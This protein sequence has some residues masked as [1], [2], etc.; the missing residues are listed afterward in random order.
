MPDTVTPP[1]LPG[2]PHEEPPFHP[3]ELAAQARAGVRERLA[4]AGRRVIRGIMP[5]QHRDFFA[6]LPFV[7]VGSLDRQGR[8]W[9][10]ILSG[11]PGFLQ[12][13][14]PRT[15]TV[16]ARPAFG[17]P[18]GDNLAEGSPVALLGIQLETRRR[19]RMNGTITERA[20]GR[21]A[22]TV[23]QSFGNCPQYIQA[24][25]PSFVAEPESLGAPRPVH[26]EGP[27]LS[28]RA[29][30]LVATADTFF[31]ATRSAEAGEGGGP[32][33]GVDVSHRGGRPGFVRV[34]EEGGRTVLT[35]PDFVGNF[36]FNTFGNIEADPR[37][38]L[39]FV[40]FDTGGVLLLT[41][42]AEVVW[43]GPEV[44]AFAG[45][46]RLLRFR[47][48]E[49]LWIEE[50]VPLRWSAPEQAPQLAATGIWDE[51]E[52]A[53]KAQAARNTLRPFTVT[54]IVE[55]SATIRSFILEPADGGSVVPY[56]PGQFLPIA[57]DI[58]GRDQPVRRTYTLSDAPDGRSYR[59]S[60]KRETGGLASRW[61]HDHVR[62]GDTIRALAPR[63][64]FTLDADSRRPVLL[65]SAGVGVTPMIAMLN[66][67]IGRN[68]DRLR[69]PGRGIWF[70]HAARDGAEHAFGTH[71]RAL[72]ARAPSLTVHVRYSR[73]RP[74]DVEGRDYDDAGHI[75]TVLLRRLLPLDD[76]DVYLC[77]PAGFMQAMREVLSGLGVR[78][79][80]IRSEAFAAGSAEPMDPAALPP[81]V[82]AAE[83]EFR[84]SG[85]SAAWD[86][87]KG[88]LLD[89]AEAA[90]IAAPW[91][92]RSGLCGTCAARVAEGAVTYAEP[93]AGAP[94]PGEALVCCAVPASGR[95]VLDL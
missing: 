21:F 70:V 53:A 5:D 46:E 65:L 26:A 11:R 55:E 51:A 34:T 56:R 76:Y 95:V 12:S 14:D 10:S 50:A 49:G 16:A 7:V 92:C 3:G 72:A 58:P 90:G 52:R 47:L 39:V 24:R 66:H 88:S 68:P 94:Q 43:D 27:V 40:D 75:D 8:P 38:G 77:G 28:P 18:L 22:V 17:D 9:A 32:S 36:Y 80:R 67:L 15:L 87:S 78:S 1:P 83:V 84:A 85:R 69:H 6:M 13:P 74:Q 29:A 35:A 42:T 62:A 48:E 86:S 61:L 23:G 63:G 20:E 82:A 25:T 33:E 45:A 73:P 44:A 71:V 19:N 57:L 4:A 41:G 89:L 54:R 31:I 37:A 60:V 81:A 91:S 79:E 30:A 93:P 59:I 2:W 64:D